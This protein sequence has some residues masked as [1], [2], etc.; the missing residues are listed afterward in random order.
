M[1]QQQKQRKDY[2]D[3]LITTLQ[4]SERRLQDIAHDPDT[5]PEFRSRAV[6]D[7]AGLLAQM[8]EMVNEIATLESET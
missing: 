3:R 6:N 5:S 1:G 2:L 7:L 4:I 8:R